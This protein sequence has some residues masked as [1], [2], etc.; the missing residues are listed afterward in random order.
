MPTNDIIPLLSNPK[1]LK[2][3]TTPLADGQWGKAFS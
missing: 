1:M 2:S 3:Q